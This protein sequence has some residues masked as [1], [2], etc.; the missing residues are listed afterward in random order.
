MIPFLSVSILGCGW[1]GLPLAKVLLAQ[2]YCI[3]GSTTDLQKIPVLQKAGIFSFCL[4]VIEKVQGQGIEDF[5]DSDVVV[6]TLP[7]RRDFKNPQEY[8]NQIKAIVFECEKSEKVKFVI[9]TSST[10]IYPANSGQAY[11]DVVFQPEHDRSKVLL[12]IE[13]E[14]LS[15]QFFAATIV[16]LAGLYGPGRKIGSFLSGQR[17]LNGPESPVNL[18][19][20]GD[21]I[22]LLKEIIVQ[23]VRGEIFNACSD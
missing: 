23:N 7:F 21:A 17:D 8:Y 9:F 16:R 15:S 5:F 18:I 13:R 11:E 10:S 19:H 12:N 2:G 1:V 3:K 4:E 20:Q 6:I 14:L 22:A